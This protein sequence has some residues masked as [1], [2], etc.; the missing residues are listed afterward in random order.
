MTGSPGLIISSGGAITVLLHSDQAVNGTGFEA[1]WTCSFPAAPPVSMFEISDSV[2]CDPTISFTDIST[3][4]PVSWIWDFGDGN[5]SSVQHP[6]HSYSNSG[7]YTVKL[8][9]TNQYG[10]D[11]VI[12][13]NAITIIDVDIQ[14][15]AASSCIDTSLTLWATS[16]AGTISWYDDNSLNNQDIINYQNKQMLTN[17]K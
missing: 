8:T 1:D 11:S 9:T 5:F 17:T 2:S 15:M 7:V 3:N 4:G 14:T 13:N 12:I 10:T 6:V 16:S